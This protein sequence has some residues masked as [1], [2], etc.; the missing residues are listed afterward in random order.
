MESCDAELQAQDYLNC[1]RFLMAA[2]KLDDGEDAI[3]HAVEMAQED[4]K[5]EYIIS[6]KALLIGLLSLSDR[7]LILGGLP[8]D[9]VFQAINDLEKWEKA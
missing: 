2:E 8:R 1:A 4:E 7:A 3:F 9:E 5:R 6:G